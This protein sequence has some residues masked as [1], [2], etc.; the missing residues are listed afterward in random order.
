VKAALT[1]SVPRNRIL[2]KPAAAD[3]A[4]RLLDALAAAL[5]RGVHAIL[6]EEKRAD[7]KLSRLAEMNVNRDAASSADRWQPQATGEPSAYSAPLRYV[8]QGGRAVSHRVEDSPLAAMLL[9][10]AAAY[11]I[12]Y[13]MHGAHSRQ[14]RRGQ[15]E[16][17]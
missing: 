15:G 14:E 10:G 2:A 12:A 1:R 11:L 17:G 16:R 5:A 6:G 3:P 4:E 8:R 7:E 13:I 9:T